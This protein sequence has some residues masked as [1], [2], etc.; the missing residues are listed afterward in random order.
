MYANHCAALI[1]KFTFTSER[2][3]KI[4][5]LFSRP[6]SIFPLMDCIWIMCQYYISTI[7][8]VDSP[9]WPLAVACQEVTRTKATQPLF[10]VAPHQSNNSLSSS[11][12]N[13][14]VPSSNLNCWEQCDTRLNTH[15]RCQLRWR[16]TNPNQAYKPTECQGDDPSRGHQDPTPSPYIQLF[17][18]SLPLPV[19]Y[20]F[21]LPSRYRGCYGGSRHDEIN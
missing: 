2:G 6:C 13:T 18:V 8:D 10:T 20:T 1:A 9:G 3:K 12:Y 15:S 21:Y 7:S 16:L 11:K 5:F 14:V 17:L 19:D 4:V